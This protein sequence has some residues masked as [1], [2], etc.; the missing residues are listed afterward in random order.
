[1][2]KRLKKSRYITGFD[3]LRSLAVIGVILYHLM[4]YQLKGGFLGVPIF[5]VLSGYLITDQLF[6]EWKQDNYI[7]I[8]GFYM[9]RMRRLYP[10]LVALLIVTTAYI[11]LFERSLLTNIRGII[12]SN[13]VYLYN[14]FQIH[15]HESYFEHLAVQSPFTHLWSLSIEGQFYLFWPIIV[16][17]CAKYIGKKRHI[18]NI[19]LLGSLLSFLMM[20]TLYQPNQDPSRVYYGTDTRIFSIL[21]GATLAVIW[22]SVN[23]KPRLAKNAK[24]VL[25]LIGGVSLIILCGLFLVVDDQSELLYRGGMY[26]YS[27]LACL[28]VA[29]VAH[30]GASL[31]KWLT[32]PVFSW[33]GKRSYGIYLYQYPLMIFYESKVQNIAAHPWLHA[34]V[35]ILLI[36]AISELSYRYLERPLQ[37]VDLT[38]INLKHKKLQAK[39][40]LMTSVSVIALVG[41][42]CAKK[43]EPKKDTRLQTQIAQNTKIVQKNNAKILHEKTVAAPPK[44]QPPVNEHGLT[45][46]QSQQ[47][48]QMKLTALGD[49]V[50]ADTGIQLQQIFTQMYVDAK[51]GR[52]VKDVVP[53]LQSLNANNQLGDKLLLVLGT[54]GPFSQDDL[55]SIMQV[56]G[57]RQVYWV[58]VHVPTRRWQD[59]VNEDLQAATKQYKNIKVIDWFTYSQNHP[60]WFY[61][62]NI[63][64][65]V[66]GSKQFATFVAREILK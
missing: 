18:F 37:K 21:L 43:L 2:E 9:R 52:Q 36:L 65:N 54:N 35:E 42:V 12:G 25:N 44:K 6:Q 4:P 29:V 62:D 22:P 27:L 61:E 58:N 14:W 46:K 10:A 28:V 40:F 16:G 41:I 34:L 15:L 11:T 17:L 49:S 66:D 26:F 45:A 48:Q 1:M 38:N 53:I 64:P 7:D 60:D 33:L 55:A 20:C 56:V 31:N 5:F 51:V 39:L 8:G 59:Q 57:Q 23:L 32:N 13:L 30:P 50:L 3:S 24:C 19:F 63:H 47:A